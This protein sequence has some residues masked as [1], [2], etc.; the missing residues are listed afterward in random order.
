MGSR[1]HPTAA[2]SRRPRIARR[3]VRC[4]TASTVALAL[5]TAAGCGA[6]ATTGS[7]VGGA[8]RTAPPT[9]AAAAG[10]AAP[11]G[12][13]VYVG[14]AEDKET[15]NP[16]PATFPV[17]WAGAPNTTFLGSTVPGQSACG[18]LPVCYDTGAIRLDNPGPS[19]ITVDRVDVDMHSSISGGKTFN[20]LW[21]SFTVQPG[22][23]VI[24]AANPPFTNPS[25]DNFDTSG[26]PPNQCTPLTI[27]PTVTITIAGAPTTLADSTHVLDT[28]GI[29]A[30]YCKQNE[31]RQ[32]RPI[33]ATGTNVATLQLAPATT[34][35]FA[36]QQV[37][38]TA[39]LLDGGGA[40][41]PNATVH[42]VVTSG[43][44]AGMA[45]DIVTDNYG[46]AGFTY[47]DTGDGED[48]VV[49]SVTTV[50][51]FHS[52]TSRVVWADDSAT[53]WTATDIGGATPAGN[54]SLNTVTGTWQ[55]Q[56]GGGPTGATSD[57]LHLVSR[58]AGASGGVAA[59]LASLAGPGPAAE[60][61]LMMRA[62]GTAGSPY[63]AAEIS[64]GGILT[65]RERTA[66]GATPTTLTQQAATVPT[67]LWIARSGARYTA[68]TSTDGYTF[69]PLAGSAATL[70]L[71]SAPLAGLSANSQDPGQS[72]TATFDSVMT[73][74]PAP[75]PVPPVTC[76]S[77]WTCA[78]IG[79]PTPAGS[80][81]FDPNSGTW[82]VNAGGADIS[83]TADQFRFDWQQVTGD[84]SVIADVTAQTVSSTQAKAGLMIRASSDP[85]APNYAVVVTPGAGIKVQR[86]STVGASTTKLANPAGTVP[87]YF[88]ITRVGSTFTAYTSSNGTTWT[89][90]P[91]STTNMPTMPATTLVGLAVT[92]HNSAAIGTVTISQVALG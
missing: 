22:R 47:T 38:E 43:P 81:S 21:G 58:P 31:S 36:G 89:L 88:E 8:A 68:Y 33:G 64:T 28:G 5:V 76:P 34:T 82:T 70:D 73:G 13:S 23:S 54:Q 92:S 84:V 10:S 2:V 78:D 60:A 48:A 32:W 3:A 52:D 29:D 67:S 62:D 91:G 90:I 74:N 1:L 16:V 69:V 49:A 11:G 9:P 40:P 4:A 66:P 27:A 79:N 45:A 41:S 12:L 25:Y 7:G 75:A 44:N 87:R 61:G 6:V 65:I 30:G 57:L 19:P 51:T 24:L 71:G 15:N 80:D 50:G 86:R 77:P 42:F 39:T 35:A 17:P 56:G 83:G 14:Y 26:Y 63:Y 46:H 85:A 53:G 72:A 20:N 18:T 59:H 37:T 55:L